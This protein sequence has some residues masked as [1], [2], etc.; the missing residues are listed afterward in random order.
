MCNFSCLSVHISLTEYYI[1][2]RR[3]T[4]IDEGGEGG[5]GTEHEHRGAR[6]V[7][8]GLPQVTHCVCVCECV[9]VVEECIERLHR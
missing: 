5:R 8:P 9:S 1:D 6:P 7:R 4:A 3:R 2:V